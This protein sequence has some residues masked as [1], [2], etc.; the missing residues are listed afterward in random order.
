MSFAELSN[1]QLLPDDK[2]C[3]VSSRD[4]DQLALQHYSALVHYNIDSWQ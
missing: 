3:L 2:A 4:V 1:I